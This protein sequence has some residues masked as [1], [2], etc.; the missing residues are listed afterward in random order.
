VDALL[1][2]DRDARTRAAS[3]E[4]SSDVVVGIEAQRYV[5]PGVVPLL[6]ALELLGDTFGIVA[7]RRDA[8]ARLAPDLLERRAR[9]AEDAATVAIDLDRVARLRLAHRMRHR[10]QAVL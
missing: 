8:R 2:Q 4:R 6:D 1:T 7:Q 3:D 9:L 5:Q 10:R